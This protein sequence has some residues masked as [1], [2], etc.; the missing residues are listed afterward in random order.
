MK[1]PPLFESHKKKTPFQI[2]QFLTL[3]SHFYLAGD[4]GFEPPIADSESTALPLGESPKYICIWKC[5]KYNEKVNFV[6][7]KCMIF[8]KIFYWILLFS[9]W[10]VLIKFRKTI[11]EWTGKFA[12]AERYIWSGWTVLVIILTWMFLMF[13]SVA[14]PAWVFEMPKSDKTLDNL[15]SR[16]WSSEN[17][18]TNR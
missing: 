6:K 13:L 9:M 16:Y 10:A 1:I 12:W 15:D 17:A 18:D 3:N 4:E 7:L 14:Y 5:G 8:L 11:Y 2:S